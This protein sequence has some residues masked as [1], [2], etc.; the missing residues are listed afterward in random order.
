MGLS[1]KDHVDYLKR[2]IHTQQ[3]VIMTINVVKDETDEKWC[4]MERYGRQAPISPFLV[5]KI[6]FQPA[7]LW[8]M[9]KLK[10]STE[11][12]IIR[13]GFKFRSASSKI[14]GLSTT[15]YDL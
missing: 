10:F 2:Q 8:Q 7:S 12:N 4:F 1:L 11:Q 6:Q 3:Y 13:S 15:L 14:S 5:G 9:E